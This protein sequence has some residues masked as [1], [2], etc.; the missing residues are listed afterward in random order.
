[1]T[2]AEMLEAIDYHRYWNNG[3]FNTA[4]NHSKWDDWYIN[5]GDGYI[6]FGNYADKKRIMPEAIKLCDTTEK[7]FETLSDESLADCL[8]YMNKQRDSKIPL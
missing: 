3:F 4:S 6:F 7:T 1:M 8:K 5:P 2:R